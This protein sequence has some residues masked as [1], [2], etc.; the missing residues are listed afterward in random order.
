MMKLLLFAA[1]IAD[2]RFPHRAQSYVFEARRLL[3][4][5]PMGWTFAQVREEVAW[6]IQ[7]VSEER[8][9]RG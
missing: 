4:A 9:T 5:R 2:E 8:G 7:G 6:Y 1:R 3:P